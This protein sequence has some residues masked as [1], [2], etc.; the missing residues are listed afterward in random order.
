MNEAARKFDT[1]EIVVEEV[2]PHAPDI[3]RT[4]RPLAGHDTDRV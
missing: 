4:D 1:Q 2:F 3:R